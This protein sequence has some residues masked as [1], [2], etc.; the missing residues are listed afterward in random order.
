MN[1]LVL[2]AKALADPSRLRI[3]VCLEGSALCLSHLTEILELA[4][5]TVSKHVSIL[6]EA[7]L[8]TQRKQGRWH[9]YSWA[10]AGEASACAQAA[11]AWVKA[12]A[13][14]HEEARADRARRQVALQNSQAPSPRESKARVLFLC[15]GNSCRSQM[16]EALLRHRAGDRFEVYSGGLNPK[17]IPDLTFEVMDEIGI[18]IRGQSPKG[19]GPFLGRMHFGHLI[20][21]CSR[22]EAQCPIFPGV[23]QRLY[24]PIPDPAAATGSRAKRLT[25]F[26]RARDELRARI[27]QWLETHGS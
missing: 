7:G 4:P 1:E 11:L 21:V 9:Y 22:A 18:D 23:S 26:R 16:A 27:D 13:V 5:A 3:L 10:R 14:D 6:A 24:W 8:L 12:H 25:A 19:L 20:T 15:T 2:I 17:P